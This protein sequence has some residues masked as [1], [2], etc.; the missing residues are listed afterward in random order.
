M[1]HGQSAA[2]NQGGSSAPGPDQKADESTRT[3]ASKRGPEPTGTARENTWPQAPH[4]LL[5]RMLAFQ[6]LA[7]GGNK[8]AVASQNAVKANRNKGTPSAPKSSRP[9]NT[10]SNSHSNESFKIPKK[11]YSAAAGNSNTANTSGPAA[12]I[13]HGDLS[14]EEEASLHADSFKDVGK[15]ISVY[16]HTSSER[17][18]K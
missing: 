12:D 15:Q 17:R 1:A 11:M 2:R 8:P 3:P 13:E 10:Q 7:P 6:Q 9:T 16:I 5:P 14:L 4:P 18:L